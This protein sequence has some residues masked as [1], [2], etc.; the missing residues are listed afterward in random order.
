MWTALFTAVVGLLKVILGDLTT[1]VTTPTTA[2]DA[3]PP[4]KELSDAWNDSIAGHP[5]INQPLPRKDKT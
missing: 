2:K 3:P 5:G 4:P 1:L